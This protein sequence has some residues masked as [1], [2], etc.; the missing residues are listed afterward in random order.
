MEKWKSREVGTWPS[1]P[2]C[3]GE[4]PYGVGEMP[5]TVAAYEFSIIL[6]FLRNI[7][8]PK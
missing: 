5:Y 4:R 7:Y 1:V 8:L 2:H 3:V 6:L